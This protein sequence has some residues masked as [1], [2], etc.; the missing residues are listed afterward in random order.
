MFV[1]I[2]SPHTWYKDITKDYL[3]N[4]KGILRNP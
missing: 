4:H 3:G 2:P 1:L